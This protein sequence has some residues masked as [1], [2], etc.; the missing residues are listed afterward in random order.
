MQESSGRI[1][2]TNIYTRK[3]LSDGIN[4]SMISKMA[5]NSKFNKLEEALTI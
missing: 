3:Q 5:S 4:V 2:M 1:M